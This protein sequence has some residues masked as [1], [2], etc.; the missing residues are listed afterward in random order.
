MCGLLRSDLVSEYSELYSTSLSQLRR[1]ILMPL[2][3][4]KSTKAKFGWIMYFFCP[5]LM[6]KVYKFTKIHNE[7]NL[8][9]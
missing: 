4:E 7:K 1:G 6:A 2:R 8:G 9:G 3:M 5:E